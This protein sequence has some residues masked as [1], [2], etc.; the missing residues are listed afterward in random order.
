MKKIGLALLMVCSL[1]GATH[2]QISEGGIPWSQT[3]HY[4]T[5]LGASV[6][7]VVLQE[8][9]YVKYQ[10]ED[11]IDALTGAAKPYR[12]AA[13][14]LA[15]LDLNKNGTWSYMADGSK[16]WR[17]KVEVPG[18]KALSLHF[19]QFQL[20]E[21][22]NMFVRNYNGQQILGAYNHNNNSKYNVF[23]HEELQG[24]IAVIE[25]NIDKNVD[26]TKIPF[27]ID[28]VWAFYRGVDE[29]N[30]YAATDHTV[31]K[32]TINESASC[33]I[34]ANCPQGDGDAFMKAKNATVRI[35]SGGGWCSGSLINNTGNSATGTCKPYLLSASHCDGSNSRNDAGFADWVFKFNY[36]FQDCGTT[37]PTGDQTMTGASFRA[38]SN[39]PSFESP[40]NSLVSDF[41]LL[42]LN[43]PIPAEYDAYLVGWN[44]R[45]D[46]FDDEDYDKYIGFHHPGGDAKKLSIGNYI[47]P[48][49]R[50]N[51]TSIN[52]THWDI[53]FQ[54]GGTAGGSSGSG[55]F[56]KDGLLIGDL[57]GGPGGTCPADDRD[58]GISAGYSKISYAWENNFDQA[59]YPGAASRLKDWLD[60]LN[61]GATSILSTKYDCSD[62]TS[63]VKELEQKLQQSIS[64]YPNPSTNGLIKAKFNLAKMSSVILTVINVLGAHQA[65]FSI[66]KVQSGDFSV[67]LSHLANGVYLVNFMVDGI[68]IS[69]KVVLT[70]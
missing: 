47:L 26:I 43:S 21:G 6:A 66:P 35:F 9:D 42:E 27:H 55:L 31:L 2:A 56:D 34:N 25:L 13:K 28:Y 40:N 8:P 4:Q 30:R 60:P 58:Y 67:D 65:S 22:V 18:A 41:L 44:R 54:T 39:Y 57:S 10:Q 37:Y 53:T 17:L 62:F 48:N 70:K 3:A 11:K 29:L 23:I 52:G 1:G 63:S 49:G 46:I 38:R 68:E 61:T 14:T 24:N 36:Q 15:D 5:L 33:H 19:D 16:V 51:Q 64:I 7:G 20:P 32:P 69:K 59:N 50:F 12:V 45:L